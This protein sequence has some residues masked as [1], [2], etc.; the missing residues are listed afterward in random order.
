LIPKYS[1]LKKLQTLKRFHIL[2]TTEVEL[3]IKQNINQAHWVITKIQI[4]TKIKLD[5]EIMHRPW[6]LVIFVFF[7]CLLSKRD[8]SRKTLLV[9]LGVP[10]PA[11]LF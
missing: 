6:C 8:T 10:S 5:Q 2:F 1:G 4:K 11:K 7:D 3:K 9:S